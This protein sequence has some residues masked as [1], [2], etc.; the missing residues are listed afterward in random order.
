[1]RLPFQIK[2]PRSRRTTYKF[3]G[4]D[5]RSG[6]AE[7][8]FSDMLNMSGVDNE[9]IAS[10][11]K[12]GSLGL[13]TSEIYSMVTT[14]VLINGVI[15]ENAFIVD[16]GSRLRAFYYENGNVRIGSDSDVS[17]FCSG[18]RTFL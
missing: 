11:K 15:R 16:A 9:C 17:F 5:K 10:R 3:N 4:L 6:A 13:N 18:F 12:R 14:D 2:I 7:S 1:M 8:Y